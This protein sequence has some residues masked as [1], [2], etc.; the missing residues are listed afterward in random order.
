MWITTLMG[1]L[2]P[3]ISKVMDKFIPDANDKLAAKKELM[4]LAEEMVGH[5]KDIILAEAKSERWFQA[6]WRPIVGWSFSMMAIFMIL[7]SSIIKPIFHFL[8]GIDLPELIIS[9][10]LWY[11]VFFCLGGYMSLRTIEKVVKWL[12]L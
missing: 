11:A 9:S 4:Y 5:K 2:F 10:E 6:L 12:K 8:T 7:F 3:I 1:V